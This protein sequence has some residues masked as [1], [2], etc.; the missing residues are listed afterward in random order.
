MNKKYNQLV[1]SLE[2]NQNNKKAVQMA[3]YMRNKFC[4]YGVVA[5]KRK[6]L[7]KNIINTDKKLKQIDWDFL[8]NCYKDD[9]RELQYVANDYLKA[10]S[11][12]LT[13]KDINKL[14][15]YA[16]T[17][18]WWDTI[19]IL[20]TLIGDIDFPNAKIDNLML[21]LSCD[22]DF[23][24]RRIAIDHQNKRKEKTNSKLLETIICNNFGQ[25]EFFINKA[26]G[27]SLRQYSKFNP[28]WVKEFIKKYKNK[29]SNLSIREALKIINKI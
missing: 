16:K 25:K 27:W 21:E 17:K 19:D 15:F 26:I 3:A 7:S 1:E 9:H 14:I 29:M 10:L 23:W 20:D 13:I 5:T 11:K 6:E 8:D 24:L 22:Q 12:Y 28:K 18:Q 4:F 2:Q